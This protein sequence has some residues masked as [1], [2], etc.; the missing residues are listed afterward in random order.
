MNKINLLFGNLQ[1]CAYLVED[2]RRDFLFYGTAWFWF[3]A[4]GNK[5]KTRIPF[6]KKKEILFLLE[7]ENGRKIIGIQGNKENMLVVKESLRTLKEIN[8]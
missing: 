6:T 1:K 2:E 8:S 7:K 5:L 3:S 4:Y